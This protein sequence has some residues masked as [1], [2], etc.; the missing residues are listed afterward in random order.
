MCVCGQ[1]PARKREEADVVGMV[2]QCQHY[3]SLSHFSL[4]CMGLQEIEHKPRFFKKKKKVKK[5]ENEQ[6]AR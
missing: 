5:G 6:C 1:E 2:L 3:Y 4:V